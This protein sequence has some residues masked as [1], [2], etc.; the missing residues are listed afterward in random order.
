MKDGRELSG[1]I[2]A[3]TASS[4]TLRT[5]TGGEEVLLRNQIEIFGS[6]GLSLM[7]E[8]FEG[9]LNAREMSDLIAFLRSRLD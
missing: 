7:P 3:E 9:S 2:A 8:G 1:V 5:A 6:S 4:V